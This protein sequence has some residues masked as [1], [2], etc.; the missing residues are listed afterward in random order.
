MSHYPWNVSQL[1]ATGQ[2]SLLRLYA[3][4]GVDLDREQ[5]DSEA[6]GTPTPLHY[7]CANGQLAVVRFLVN[8][9]GANAEYRTHNGWTPLLS[10]ASGGY[11]PVVAFLHE[12]VRVQMNAS[13]NNG[14]TALHCAVA[15]GHLRTAVYLIEKTDC[16]VASVTSDGWTALHVAVASP[17]PNV[18]LVS[19]LLQHFNVDVHTE[20]D[21]QTSLHLAA[22][23][24]AYDDVI[25]LLLHRGADV[26]ATDKFDIEPL[27]YA[28]RRGHPR[29]MD[30][31]RIAR[32]SNIALTETYCRHLI[33][34]TKFDSAKETIERWI[35]DGSNG[36]TTP[37][38][39][40]SAD[41]DMN[42][43]LEDAVGD[44]RFPSRFR[45]YNRVAQSDDRDVN[46][47]HGDTRAQSERPER[48][49]APFKTLFDDG[50]G[51]P[52]IA[53]S[54]LVANRAFALSET[55]FVTVFRGAHV[56]L[57]TLQSDVI[58]SDTIAD[59][60]WS[61]YLSAVLKPMSAFNH[62]HI[63]VVM[64]VVE[65]PH[66]CVVREYFSTSLHTYLTP[67][68]NTPAFSSRTSMDRSI[69]T[70][71]IAVAR[72][73]AFLHEQTP[74]I[75]HRN[76]NAHNVMIET[77]RGVDGEPIVR[78]AKLTD[79]ALPSLHTV[80][81]QSPSASIAPPLWSHRAPETIDDKEDGDAAADVF[82]FGLL[83]VHSINRTPPF[84]FLSQRGYNDA[85]DNDALSA[86]LT[87]SPSS[88]YAESMTDIVRRCCAI[89]RQTRPTMS[90]VTAEL[91][92]LEQDNHLH[93]PQSI[94]TQCSIA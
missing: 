76:V 40:Q 37:Q 48:N 26:T 75:A 6:D 87:L 63:A 60:R 56:V 23:L 33:A 9:I 34:L 16:R 32:Q 30:V 85:L 84:S 58:N 70:A 91:E 64:G 54:P 22:L 92:E 80:T 93:E 4:A 45:R 62:P 73:L 24:N 42:G 7:A 2:L 21:R 83:I 11:T 46:D 61:D 17:T 20:T 72:A 69:I 35:D 5:T 74:P 82:A 49:N 86:F 50:A 88:V 29:C 38:T 47:D 55:T 36:R 53:Y 81:P 68:I 94:T 25:R 43:E 59:S 14:F 65:R 28:C 71:L 1:A 51:V 18:A 79:T 15:S 13:A 78:N 10:A 89:D 12:S 3:A 27:A 31:I 77:V 66:R 90:V 39:E 41:D 67:T 57:R 52:V 19:Y 8:E 44:T